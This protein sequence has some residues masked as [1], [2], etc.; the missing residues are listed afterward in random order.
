MRLL[1]FLCCAAWLVAFAACGQPPPVDPSKS[2]SGLAPAEVDAF[3]KETSRALSDDDLRRFLCSMQGQVSLAFGD[4]KGADRLASCE[5]AVDDCTKS[6]QDLS[7]ARSTCALKQQAAS[8]KSSVADLKACLLDTAAE[9]K[10]VAESFSCAKAAG[11]PT[12]QAIPKSCVA[13][14]EACPLVG[15]PPMGESVPVKHQRVE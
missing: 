9:T 15:V 14:A 1:R 5:K 13:I 12:L 2:V 7:L 10:R 3:C 11:E 4:A 6:K 8:C